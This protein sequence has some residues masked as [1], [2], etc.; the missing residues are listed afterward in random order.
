MKKILL[1]FLITSINCS[2]YQLEKVDISGFSYDGKSVYLN[3]EEIA[4]LSGMEMA[5][6]DKSLVREATFVL[7]SPKYN[8]YAIEIIKIVRQENKINSKNIKFEVEVE[9]KHDYST[10]FPTDLQ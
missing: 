10:G 9:L 6:D 5:Y 8:Q 3:G 7:L 4:K 1:L 2:V